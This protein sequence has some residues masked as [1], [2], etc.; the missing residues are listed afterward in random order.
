MKVNSKDS[1]TKEEPQFDLVLPFQLANSSIRG[2][3]VRLDK[4]M[5]DIINLHK[6]P[7]VVSEYLSQA[8]AVALALINC[9]KVE[10]LFTLQIN[11]NGPLHLLV[12]DADEHGNLRACARF[13]K[14][15]IE[16]LSVDDQKKL[17]PVFGEARLT[18]TIEP[19]NS[20]QRYQ[21]IVELTGS[22]LSESIS[23]YFR[24]SEQLETGIIVVSS[25][26]PETLAAGALMIQRIPLASNVPLEDRDL[27]EEKWIH[28]LTLTG[29][30]TKK[31]LLDR[32]LSNNDLLYRL[33][34]EDG[35]VIY[36]QK[37]YKAQ[38]RCSSDKIKNILEKFSPTEIHEMVENDAISATCEFCGKNYTFTEEEFKK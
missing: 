15:K 17:H 1:A 36:N 37:T 35:A 27:Q 2:R 9:F 12:V 38:C 3:L 13:D 10:G 25:R 8:S 21:G 32:T 5:W 23:H 26:N 24:Q 4:E 34:W 31:E 30:V 29:S 22:N 16:L 18:F 14:D 20:S 6:Y 19:L 33:F 7:E 11:G 28:A